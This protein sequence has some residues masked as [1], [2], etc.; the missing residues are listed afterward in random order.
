MKSTFL[1]MQM[2]HS[3]KITSL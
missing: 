1:F 2:Q 3:K